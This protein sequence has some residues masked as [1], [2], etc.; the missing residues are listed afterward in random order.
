MQIIV[1]SAAAAAAYAGGIAAPAYGLAAPALAHGYASPT[2]TAGYAAPLAYAAA[3]PV[4]K[5]AAAPVVAKA[6]IAYP[7]QPYQFG[8]ESVDEYGTKQARHEVSD[9]Y[10][11][12]KGSYSFVDARG[13]SRRVD[14]VADVAGFRATIHTNEPGTAPSAPAAA[15]YNSAPVAIKAIGAAPVA[16][17]TVAA[18][19]VA[20]YAKAP[21]TALGYGP[22]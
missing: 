14:Y 1:A 18:A 11:N 13:I 19:P 4:A 20:A 9:A 6:D 2:L 21:V 15:L 10:N 8:Y 7:P 12:K 16:V 17:K 5:I 3:A 22:Y